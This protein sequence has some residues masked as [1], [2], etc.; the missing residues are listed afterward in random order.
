MKKIL[1]SIYTDKYPNIDAGG[2]NNIIYKIIQQSSN[3]EFIF[4]YLSSDLFVE[5]IKDDNLYSFNEQ[6]SIK[7]KITSYLGENSQLY[8][9]IFTNKFYLPYHFYKKNKRYKS[10]NPHSK[11]Y[12]IIHSHDSISLS[13]LSSKKINSSKI[14]SVHSKGPLSDELKNMSRS[15]KISDKINKELKI[16]EKRSIESADVITFPSKASREYFENSL[17]INLDDDKVRIIYNGIDYEYIKNIN[18]D[19]KILHKYSISK[20]NYE[21]ILL[22][23][24]AHEHEK[25]IDV[26]LKVIQRLKFTYKKNVLLVNIGVGSLTDLLIKTTNDIGIS[27]NVR[28]LGK[29]PND[30]VIKFLKLSDIFIMTSEKV[31]FDLVVLEA[32]A[33]GKCVIV[34]NDGGNKEIIRDGENGYLIDIKDVDKISQKIISINFDK[35]KMKALET[36]KQFSVK[37]MA[38][39]YS[40]LYESI[41]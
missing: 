31:I 32:L 22:N 41:L 20:N 9:N 11:N 19:E 23:I 24:S 30:D 40:H 8:R 28:F 17:E 15:K 7:K 18:A 4:D 1:Y 21:L 2:P 26:L 27:N 33:C 14:L 34:S 29:I 5:N 39:E 25:K 35:T 6:L 13:L 10:F 36:A 16:L 38:K 3:R 12:D 37:K